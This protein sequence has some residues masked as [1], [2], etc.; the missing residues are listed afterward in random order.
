MNDDDFTD[1]TLH[2]DGQGL[3][4]T[5]QSLGTVRL[6]YE[7]PEVATTLYS[8][9]LSAKRRLYEACAKE[10][11][12]ERSDSDQPSADLLDAAAEVIGLSGLAMYVA[13]ELDEQKP[14]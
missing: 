1:I 8:L 14:L 12:S 10:N 11:E 3:T 9:T 5:G 2:D 4:L 6:R 13:D 7:I